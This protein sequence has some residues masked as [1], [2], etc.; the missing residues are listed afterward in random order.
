M[1]KKEQGEQKATQ[2]QHCGPDLFFQHERERSPDQ[3]KAEKIDQ[4]DLSRYGG[5]EGWN[6]YGAKAPVIKLLAC[7][8][9]QTYGEETAA[10]F[11]KTFHPEAVLVDPNIEKTP[12]ISPYMLIQVGTNCN[13]AFLNYLIAISYGL[14][15]CAL[16]TLSIT[17]EKWCAI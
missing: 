1:T 11:S 7:H 14:P 15:Q 2:E 13:A 12:R 9:D 5:R 8:S 17:Y 6:E 3:K 10:D 16:S 4:H